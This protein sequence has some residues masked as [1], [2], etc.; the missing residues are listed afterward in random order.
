VEARIPD[1]WFTEPLRDAIRSQSISGMSFR[2]SVRQDEWSRSGKDRL[3]N[4]KVVELFELGPVVFPAYSDTSVALRSLERATGITAFGPS[5]AP[6]ITGTADEPAIADDQGT[7]A[8]STRTKAQRT[9]LAEAMR[10]IL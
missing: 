8:P 7:P 10:S 6:A 9:A 5:D 1:N 4:L 3:R 2:F